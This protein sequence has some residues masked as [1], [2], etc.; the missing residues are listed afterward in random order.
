M[1]IG[2]DGTAMTDSDQIL[3]DLVGAK[4]PLPPHLVVLVKSWPAIRG[5]MVML[6]LLKY[7][8]LLYNKVIFSKC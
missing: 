8:Q 7:Y 6:L 2:R 4:Q 1:V 3:D 5:G